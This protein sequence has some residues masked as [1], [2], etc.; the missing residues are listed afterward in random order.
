[1]GQYKSAFDE[2][3]EAIRIAHKQ[4]NCMC[5]RFEDAVLFIDSKATIL[6]IVNQNFDTSL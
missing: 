6:A 2:E 1:M 4:P 5:S 3:V